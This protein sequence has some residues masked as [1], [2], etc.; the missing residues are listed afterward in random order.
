M[1][2]FID[3]EF[4]D[5]PNDGKIDLISIGMVREDGK[6]FYA[7]S[8]EFNPHLCN[9]WVQQNVLCHLEFN[10]AVTKVKIRDG[11][12]RA[13]KEDGEPPEFWGY[14]ADYDWVLFCSLFGGMLCLPKGWPQ[15]CFDVRQEMQRV[16]Y[17]KADLPKAD[18][19]QAHNA[20][21]DAQWTRAVW[22]WLQTRPGGTW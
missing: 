5:R 2:W 17:R 8:C 12:K 7:E 14:F 4:N 19:S 16:G 6:S 11:I 15:L 10:H 13:I 1:R 18:P 21:Y 22:Q 20:L 9:P 3:T